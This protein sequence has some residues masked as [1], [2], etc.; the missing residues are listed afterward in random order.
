MSYTVIISGHTVLKD[1]VLSFSL[2]A[3][4]LE[5]PPLFWIADDNAG[6]CC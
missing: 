3:L 2:S 6:H 5:S 1:P 4:P